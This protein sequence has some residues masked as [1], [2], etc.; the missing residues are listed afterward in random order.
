MENL[1]KRFKSLLELKSINE[2]ICTLFQYV[3]SQSGASNESSVPARKKRSKSKSKSKSEK[4]D[5]VSRVAESSE[6]LQSQSEKQSTENLEDII[7]TLQAK[8]F[9]DAGANLKS[10]DRSTLIKVR[11]SIQQALTSATDECI[12]SLRS[13]LESAIRMKKSTFALDDKYKALL[14][15]L[16]SKLSYSENLYAYVLFDLND[17]RSFSE[18]DYLVKVKLQFKLEKLLECVGVPFCSIKSIDL[19]NSDQQRRIYFTNA[20]ETMEG[21]S[22][23]SEWYQRCY[24]GD[25]VD[26]L[27]ILKEIGPDEICAQVNNIRK[28]DSMANENIEYVPFTTADLEIAWGH[29]VMARKHKKESD[30]IYVVCADAIKHALKLCGPDSTL[31]IDGHGG[32]AGMTVGDYGRRLKREELSKLFVNIIADCREKISHVILSSCATGTL[33]QKWANSA[34]TKRPLKYYD[35]KNRCKLPIQ[36]D[37]KV[38]DMFEM[39][40]SK[41]PVAAQ[42]ASIIFDMYEDSPTGVAFTFSPSMLIPQF[43]SGNRAFISQNEEAR[44]PWPTSLNKE[45]T[46]KD[47]N[48]LGPQGGRLMQQIGFK[49]ITLFQSLK[50]RKALEVEAEHAHAWKKKK[51]M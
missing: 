21:F 41:P 15:E 7:E 19:E 27:K 42:L 39:V 50:N 45:I 5:S 23:F 51:Q 2:S 3:Q 1:E 28:S 22:I 25:E 12:Q 36:K 29:L 37:S 44:D 6:A 11:K 16:L 47:D 9:L 8:S 43:K 32:G 46:W 24:K 17:I 31:V 13:C 20:K 33:I 40:N 4:K 26:K 35:F 38:E 14:P 49:S 18:S 48:R 34:Y 30:P 10:L